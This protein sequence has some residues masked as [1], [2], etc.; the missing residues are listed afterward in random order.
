[1]ANSHNVQWQTRTI[2][3][4]TEWPT[5]RLSNSQNGQ[6]LLTE[7]LKIS[8]NSILHLIAFVCSGQKN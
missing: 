4:L 2:C 1:M 8:R 3:Q 6:Q 7:K 5:R